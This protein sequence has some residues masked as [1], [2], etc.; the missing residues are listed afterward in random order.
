MTMSVDIVGIRFF[1][2]NDSIEIL[3][4]DGEKD[5]EKDIE[6]VEKKLFSEMAIDEETW[7]C[8]DTNFNFTKSDPSV[9][10]VYLRVLEPPPE[11]I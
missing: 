9:D 2:I 3:E 6:E 10:P 11:Y 7:Y 8:P 5:F 4:A 1:E